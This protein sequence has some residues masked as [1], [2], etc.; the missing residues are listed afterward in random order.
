[1]SADSVLQGLD[2]IVKFY[3]RAAKSTIANER[4]ELEA[5]VGIKPGV[6]GTNRLYWQNAKDYCQ[7][8]KT[9]TLVS[10]IRDT[11]YGSGNDVVTRSRQ[12]NDGEVVWQRKKAIK[13]INVYNYWTRLA[14]STELFLTDIPKISGQPTYRNTTRHS[15][16]FG[17]AR[18]DFSAVNV[19][20]RD[21]TMT[22]YEMEVEF[23]GSEPVTGSVGQDLRS[24]G[25]L[26][27]TL[28]QKMFKSKHIFSYRT[29]KNVSRLV[30]EAL[31][32]FTGQDTV[33]RALMSE[34]K[35]LSVGMIRPGG[36]VGETVETAIKYRMS[37][38]A[39]GHRR[40]LI[41]SKLGTWL[42]YPPYEA[43]LLAQPTDIKCPTSV[44]DCE[45]ILDPRTDLYMLIVLD[46][47]MANG[48]DVRQKDQMERLRSF[49]VYHESPE[50]AIDKTIL[51]VIKK[52]FVIFTNENFFI[53]FGEVLDSQATAGF[54]VD[55]VTFTPVGESYDVSTF[56]NR[57][58][59]KW[60]PEI[61]IDFR[62]QRKPDGQ[63]TLQVENT[64]TVPRTL[65]DFR[66]IDKR[67]FTPDMIDL[68]NEFIREAQS[69]A[70]LEFKWVWTDR[71]QNNG[72]L[73]A[74]KNR[75]EKPSP[76]SDRVAEDN[77]LKMTISSEILTEEDLRGDTSTLM[78]ASHNRIKAHLFSEAAG[79]HHNKILLDIG[80]G[81]GADVAKW[82]GFSKIICVEPNKDNIKELEKR[83]RNVK[84]SDL[85]I[86]EAF[87]QDTEKIR[88]N[89]PKGGVDVI[90]MMD[91]LTFFF[92]PANDYED[93]RKL[94]TTIKSF[95]K[96]NGVFIW[97]ALNGQL[98]KE[99]LMT[100]RSKDGIYRFGNDCYIDTNRPVDGD[101]KVTIS[102]F[103]VDQSEWLT[104][105]QLFSRYT[106]LGG[107]NHSRAVSDP[108]LTDDFKELS[109]YYT[110]GQFS[111]L[112]EPKASAG[113]TQK[114]TTKGVTIEEFRP[115]PAL[116]SR[117]F[118]DP[119]LAI[120]SAVS[121]HPNESMV[122]SSTTDRLQA[123]DNRYES[124]LPY[125]HYETIL[126]CE[127]LLSYGD[128]LRRGETKYSLDD[129]IK[130]L[131]GKDPLDIILSL[132]VADLIGID[133]FLIEVPSARTRQAIKVKST[134]AIVDQER[135]TVVLQMSGTE[136][137]YYSQSEKI[138]FLPGD[139]ILKKFTRQ[140]QH[141]LKLCYLEFI[142]ALVDSEKMISDQTW[143]LIKADVVISKRIW[144]HNEDLK[145]SGRVVNYPSKH[146]IELAADKFAGWFQLSETGEPL[147]DAEG[148]YQVTNPDQYIDLVDE[149]AYYI[150]SML[151]PAL[152]KDEE[153]K[154][155]Q[156]YVNQIEEMGVKFAQED[157]LKGAR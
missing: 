54:P 48:E 34:A 119:L 150:V 95:L 118:K 43:I 15:Y 51:K 57:T 114:L 132:A 32:D 116:V 78:R 12:I 99:E 107:S 26:T 47:L 30:N 46:C 52:P 127:L 81:R 90:S 6:G 53:R 155:V 22:F 59:L 126:Q 77:W 83:A 82:K 20:S 156:E 135:P 60:K 110:Y 147:R 58:I 39:D 98:V 8:I 4:L 38:K 93:L 69:G 45:Y 144:L 7:S 87:G 64:K 91:S 42:I 5:R 140:P 66:G 112:T 117:K 72:K 142:D 61:T 143:E 130:T 92:N 86:I 29:L 120:L 21:T 152:E 24:F 73:V 49:T 100:Q 71:A 62:V 84:I 109:S 129:V 28:I 97:K 137:I 80:S 134:N 56:E 27:N 76:N 103:V 11:V 94:A 9:T 153:D 70:V 157:F 74:I 124:P 44:I 25:A 138:V 55:G 36:I 128:S 41:I 79:P 65:I 16:D 96:P 89:I 10:K 123:I 1:M 115:S 125:I 3:D 67:I 19:I 31:G 75:F 133:V 108:L 145:T 14:L 40:L 139:P 111:L 63:L 17:F 102:H 85:T 149:A 154:I 18:V 141:N 88:N 113:P 106:G 148:Y 131:K 37:L 121:L 122:R 2:D 13:E 68:D 151:H 23:T 33:N 105:L 35:T 101:I 50:W 136:Y 146:Y 104:D